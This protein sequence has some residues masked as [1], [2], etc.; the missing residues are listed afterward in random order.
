MSLKLKCAFVLKM[1]LG[2]LFG[3]SAILKFIDIDK[4]EL[5]VFSYGILSLNMSYLFARMC[6]G[7][8]LF[9]SMFLIINIYNKFFIRLTLYSLIGFTLFLLYAYFIGRTDNCHCFGE[10]LKFDPLQSILKNLVLIFFTLLC[11][12]GKPYHFH[13]KWYFILLIGLTPFVGTCIA[14]PPDN[15]MKPPSMFLFNTELFDAYVSEDG[16]LDS[17][18]IGKGKKMVMFYSVSCKYCKLSA[19]KISLIQERSQISEDHFYT[20]FIGEERDLSDFYEKTESKKF[21]SSFLNPDDFLRLTYGSMPVI[22]LVEEGKIKEVF[23]YRTL[24]EE[25]I[26]TFFQE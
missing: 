8:E 4:F 22:V 9:L 17:T 19:R 13:L 18:H 14:S 12:N 16:I 10:Y 3:I 6:I 25:R 23:N 15:F 21:P 11:W 24:S 5:Y 26:R 20:V 7:F 1:L 2:V